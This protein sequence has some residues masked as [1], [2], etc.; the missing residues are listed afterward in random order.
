MSQTMSRASVVVLLCGAFILMLSFGTR[1]SFG[2]FLQPMSTSLGWGREVFALALALQNLIWGVSQPFVG[3]IADKWGV[4][5][6]LAGG[7]LVYALGLCLMANTT[8]PL[9][10]HL[11]AGVLIGLA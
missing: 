5:R 2:L 3:M 9:A 11:S 8:S 1:S 6:T 10:L 4:G 7:A